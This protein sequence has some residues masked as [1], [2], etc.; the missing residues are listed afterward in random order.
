MIISSPLSLMHQIQLRQQLEAVFGPRDVSG[1]L[2]D[3][4]LPPHRRHFLLLHL[5]AC[6]EDAV[7]MVTRRSPE[8]G[9]EEMR[10]GRMWGMEQVVGVIDSLFVQ[11]R[12]FNK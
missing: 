6:L 9:G 12:T 5:S 3:S 1:C 8:G 10:A 4:T 7:A 11:R 2:P